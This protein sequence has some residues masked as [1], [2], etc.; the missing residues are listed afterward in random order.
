M[1]QPE[2]PSILLDYMGKAER[3]L[4]A[5]PTLPAKSIR[6]RRKKHP[7]YDRFT[8]YSLVVV[9]IIFTV[10]LNQYL[11]DVH[12]ALAVHILAVAAPMILLAL[13]IVLL[14]SKCSYTKDKGGNPILL[15]D[16][17]D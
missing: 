17:G 8:W 5:P 1:D 6:K 7:E 15:K 14:K 11:A 13:Y 4:V 3:D 9:G 16:T 10:A 12:T 2:A